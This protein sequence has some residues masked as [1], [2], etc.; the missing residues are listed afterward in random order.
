MSSAFDKR[1]KT[2]ARATST[3]FGPTSPPDIVWH[4]GGHNILTGDYKG[5][6]D[7]I[8]LFGRSAQEA[9]GTLKFELHDVLAN[10]THGIALVKAT[11]E[12]NGKTLD[13]NVVQVVHYNAEG[14][15]TEAWFIPEDAA[16][17][18]RGGS[19]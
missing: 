7:V 2:S 17:V 12:R 10:D 13:S 1:T 3:R 18:G 5:V 6:D 4:N 9:G 16:A 8:A 11:A 15:T 19:Y 14:Q